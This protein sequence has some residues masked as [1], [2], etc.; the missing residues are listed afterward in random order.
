MGATFSASAKFTAID[1]VTGPIK[2]MASGVKSFSQSISNDMARARANVTKLKSSFGAI[3]SYLSVASVV[4]FGN[5][6]IN[7]WGE[8]AAAIAN[9]EAGIKSTNNLLGISSRELQSMAGALQKNSIFGDELILQNVTAQMQTFTNVSKDNFARVQQAAV[10]VTS[11]LKGVKATGEDLRSTSIMLGKALNDPAQGM[12]ALRR[13]GISFSEQTTKNVKALAA[14]GKYGEAQ[15]LML[16]EIETQYGGAAAAIAKTSKGMEMIKKNAI[17]DQMEAFGRNLEPIKN[18][19]L[20]IASVALKVVNFL[21]NNPMGNVILGAVAA[22]KAYGLVMMAVA[23]IEAYRNTIQMTGISS[24]KLMALAIGAIIAGIIYLIRHWDSFSEK[25]KKIIKIVGIAIGTLGTLLGVIK[26]FTV[27]MKILNLTLLACPIT[28]IILG[29]AAV[30]AG[31]VLLIKHWDKVKEKMD[32]WSNSAIFQVLAI[33]NPIVKVIELIAFM[34]DRLEGIKKAFQSGGFLQGIIAIGKALLSF[35]I[36]P[37]EVIMK[38]IAKITGAKWASNVAGGLEKFRSSL[39]EGLLN[40]NETV[41]PVNKDAAVL[42]QKKILETNNTQNVQI[43]IDDNTGRA[44]VGGALQPVPVF[45]RNTKGG[46]G[47]S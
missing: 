37:V 44:S 27:I 39:D 34:Q 3:A 33:L 41:T 45:I 7:L 26:A 4:A 36:K 31:I 18:A 28:W 30:I 17:G 14:Q 42:T 2:K 6:S 40:Q 22:W 16:K 5:K 19:L 46:F 38:A 10:D 1:M 23:A 20:D 47:G 43:N 21:L 24:M 12:S 13:V 25:T 9:V 35:I 11:K 32:S 15:V 8:Q 29:I